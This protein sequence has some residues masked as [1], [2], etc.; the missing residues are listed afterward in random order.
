MKTSSSSESDEIKP[1]TGRLIF[2]LTV[3]SRELCFALTLVT[4]GETLNKVIKQKK[5]NP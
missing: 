4:D 5:E 3:S 2:S 1:G